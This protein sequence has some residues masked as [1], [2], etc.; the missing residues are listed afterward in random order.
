[1]A[2]RGVENRRFALGE[3][4]VR[5][6]E[7]GGQLHH[8]AL[9]FIVVDL[10]QHTGEQLVGDAGPERSAG[11]PRE[12]QVFAQRAH[13]LRQRVGLQAELARGVDPTEQRV[14]RAAD[15]TVGDGE[16]RQDAGGGFGAVAA[17]G[18]H[19]ELVSPGA[20]DGCGR[21][22]ERVAQRR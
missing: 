14:L 21:A 20:V 3:M 6:G 10:C 4:A 5:R 2:Q 17:I 13:D 15:M 16:Q 18:A 19:D 8:A 1:V 22:G 12:Q 7:F 9:Q 11:I